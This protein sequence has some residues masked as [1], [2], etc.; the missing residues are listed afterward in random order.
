MLDAGD[1][2]IVRVRM[3]GRGR[4]SG[5]PTTMTYYEVYTLR[6]GRIARHQN[7]VDADVARAAA[8]L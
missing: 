3:S 2:M 1:R 7:F 6:D 8:G 4:G 5:L